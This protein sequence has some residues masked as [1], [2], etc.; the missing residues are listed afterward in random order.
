[1]GAFSLIVVINLL[2]R[3]VCVTFISNNYS[4]SCL[5]LSRWCR[6]RRRSRSST[7]TLS[8]RRWSSRASPRGRGG[9]R[10]SASDSKHPRRPSG[11][12]TL[13]R[14]A[15]LPDWLASGRILKGVVKKMKMHRTIVIRRDYL[16]WVRK[17]K[18]YERRHKNMSVHCS[19]CFRDL[20]VG[21]IVTV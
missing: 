5:S 11:V 7:R 19:P 3:S 17:Y 8:P 15:H 18:R 21:D 2:N 12:N 16:H 1:M 9:T 14:S 20:E 13:T 6:W 4:Q 10:T